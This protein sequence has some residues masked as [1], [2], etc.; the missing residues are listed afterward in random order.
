MKRLPLLAL[1][2]S[3]L[4]SHA[5]AGSFSVT[6]V[7]VFMTPKDRAMAITLVNEGDT[8]IALQADIHSWAQKT[9]GSDQLDLTDELILSPPIIKLP[10]RGRQVV[11]L[12]LL[13]APDPSRQLTYRMIIKEVPEVTAPK[14]RVIQV[15]IALALSMPVFIT[16]PV[17]KR[18]VQCQVGAAEGSLQVSCGNQGTAYAQIREISVKQGQSQLAKFEGGTYILPGAKKNIA[19][20]PVIPVV[21][22]EAEL[23]LVFDDG[24]ELV[25]KTRLR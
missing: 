6:P 25:S 12:A 3:S 10:A 15:P 18:D 8:E 1:I 20:K 7:R 23:K 16:P 17:A 22:G 24:A 21:S 14:D 4:V 19:I 13:R 2:A 11:R 5:W 9:D